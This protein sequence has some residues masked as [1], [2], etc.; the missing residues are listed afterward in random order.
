MKVV[1]DIYIINEL[2]F[3]RKGSISAVT[4]QHSSFLQKEETKVQSKQEP[5]KNIENIA[6][7]FKMVYVQIN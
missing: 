1:F 4:N 7:L 3:S 2:Y 6:D 5:N